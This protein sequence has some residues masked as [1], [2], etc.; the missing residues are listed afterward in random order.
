MTTTM[1][2]APFTVSANFC[3][4]RGNTVG[5]LLNNLRAFNA[6]DELADAISEFKT[7]VAGQNGTVSHAQAVQNVQ[8]GLGGTVTSDTVA[9]P[10]T[11]SDRY[12][13]NYTYH[14]PDAPDLP[15]GRGKY[16]LK[17]WTSKA[18]KRLKAWVD[19]VKGPKPFSPGAAEA[20]IIWV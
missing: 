16:I 9:A 20:D 14:H 17:E 19:P 10:E 15:D 18:G 12:N 13:N 11:V 8:N 2:E 4:I 3:A 1:T 6:E 7:I 5:E